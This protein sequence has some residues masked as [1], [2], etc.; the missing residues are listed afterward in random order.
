MLKEKVCIVTGAA[1]GIGLAIA[2]MFAQEQ[3]KVV[4]VDINEEQLKAHCE[5]LNA[6]YVVADLSKRADCKN[7]VDQT[8]LRHNTV[9][10]LVNVA[11]IQTVSPIE[12]FPEDKWDFMQALMLT[13]PFLLTKYSWPFMKN[14]KWGRVINLNSI[15]GLV[16]SEFKSAYVSAKHGL[17]GLTK[18][19]ALEGGAYGITVNSICPSYV[20]TPLVDKQITAQAATHG[21]PEEEVITKIMLAKAAVKKMLEPSEVANVVKFLCADE[22]AMITGSTMTIDGGWTAA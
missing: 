10:V 11:G 16:A 12:D 5:R 17:A 4:M 19:A 6:T 15:H 8:V 18:T 20:R 2:E 14:Q 3:C 22:A 21:I 1:S 13:A 9:D 7:V